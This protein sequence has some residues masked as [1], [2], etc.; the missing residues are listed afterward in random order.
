MKMETKKRSITWT[1][2]SKDVTHAE[3]PG[4]AE[5]FLQ[6][7]GVAALGAVAGGVDDLD[8][9]LCGKA[10]A[11]G[12]GSWLAGCSLLTCHVCFIQPKFGFLGVGKNEK[13][14]YYLCSWPKII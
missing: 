12:Q 14:G 1:A 10:N 3:N 8:V 4:D 7:L 5:V 2:H 11:G 9:H 6:G 13:L